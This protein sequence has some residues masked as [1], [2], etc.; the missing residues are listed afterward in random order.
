[1]TG[2]SRCGSLTHLETHHIKRRAHGGG[3]EPDNLMRL[4]AGCHDYQHAHD[5]I[6]RQISRNSKR[7][8]QQAIW[9]HRLQVLEQLNAPEL[10]RDHGYTSYWSDVTTHYMSREAKR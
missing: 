4:C 6:M 5:N 3:D 10:I 7:P 9:Q 2:C 8:K 1:M